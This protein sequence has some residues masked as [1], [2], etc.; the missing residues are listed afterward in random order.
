M[1]NVELVYVSSDKNTF[2]L[3]M[4]LEEGATVAT[5]LE[6]SQIFTLYPETQN[7]P[8]GIYATQVAPEKVLREGDRVEIYRPLTLDP[9]EK[10]RQ[11][12][13]IKK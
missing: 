11:R 3:K 12:A 6:K 1:V 5:A 7:F 8:V 2:H 10:R 9:K 13:R 4:A